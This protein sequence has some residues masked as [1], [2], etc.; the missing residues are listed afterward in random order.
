M[1]P[2]AFTQFE[3][4]TDFRHTNFNI[5]IQS[6]FGLLMIAALARRFNFRFQ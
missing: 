6:L 4:N 1:R 5:R 3:E 2:H